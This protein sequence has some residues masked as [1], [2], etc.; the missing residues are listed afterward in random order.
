MWL[1]QVWHK[2]E[3]GETALFSTISTIFGTYSAP[4][5]TGKMSDY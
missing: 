3:K 5:G 4:P 2:L 1:R